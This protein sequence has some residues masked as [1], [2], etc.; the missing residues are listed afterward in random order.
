[1]PKRPKSPHA[2]ALASKVSRALEHASWM[3]AAACLD[4]SVDLWY[5]SDHERAEA[6][7]IRVEE[8]R[9][10]CTGCPVREECL[11][12]AIDNREPFGVWGGHTTSERRAL[13][14]RRIPA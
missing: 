14:R 3:D 7:E 9:A 12:T 13:A 2:S 10:I 1:M 6:R 5:G 4:H 11:E 8:A